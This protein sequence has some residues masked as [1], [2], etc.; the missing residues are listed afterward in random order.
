MK[1][2]RFVKKFLKNINWLIDWL[3]VFNYM[4]A[5]VVNVFPKTSKIFGFSIFWLWE[6]MMKVIPETCRAH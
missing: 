6:Y 3:I 2:E 5:L 4:Y 1:V